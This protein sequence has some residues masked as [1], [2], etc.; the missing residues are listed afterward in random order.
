MNYE[1]FDDRIDGLYKQEARFDDMM[2]YFTG[3]AI[4][5][6][7][8]GLFGMSLFAGQQRL[9]EMGIRKIIGAS[10]ENI[11]YIL[12]KEFIIL[13]IFST[14]IAVPISAYFINKWLQNFAYRVK[15]DPYIFLLSALAA[16]VIAVLSVGYQAVKIAVSNPVESLRDE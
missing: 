13:T 14:I 11:F 1:F 16:L 7:C 2:G 8:F 4:F 15:L 3:L 10:T 6:A 12:T 5:I 9:K